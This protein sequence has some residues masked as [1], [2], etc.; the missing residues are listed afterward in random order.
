M[1]IVD[2]Q[3]HI[4]RQTVVP[5]TGKHLKVSKVTAEE[6]LKWMDEAGVDAA[7]IHPPMS[8]DPT[9]QDLAQ[10]ARHDGPALG[11]LA[12]EGA[13]AAARGCARL[14]LAGGR[15]GGPRGRHDGR[16]F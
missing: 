2:A 3:V 16:H 8:W 12:A 15:E 9:S 1:K 11:A 4:W 7:L 6:M 14:D 13:G 10:A 5:T